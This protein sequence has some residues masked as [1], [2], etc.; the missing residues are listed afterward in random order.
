MYNLYFTLFSSSFRLYVSS[1]QG[2]TSRVNGV[3]T[4]VKRKSRGFGFYLFV[5]NESSHVQIS[6]KGS[7][8]LLLGSFYY[9]KSWDDLVETRFRVS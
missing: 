2:G 4:R 1:N 9:D 5:Y 6:F 8:V 7:Y 3:R